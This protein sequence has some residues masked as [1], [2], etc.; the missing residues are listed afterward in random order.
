MEVA[1]HSPSLPAALEESIAQAGQDHVLRFWNTLDGSARDRLVGQ[2]AAI[3]WGMFSEL[4]R[5]APGRG[6]A[7]PGLQ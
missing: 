1:M 7:D 2:L 5:L 3:D 6:G 4:R